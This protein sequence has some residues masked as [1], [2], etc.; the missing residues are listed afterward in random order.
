MTKTIEQYAAESLN[1]Q[2]VRELAD[3]IKSPKYAPRERHIDDEFGVKY[4]TPPEPGI[5]HIHLH[6]GA[7]CTLTR[8]TAEMLVV[9]NVQHGF[10]PGMPKNGR[11]KIWRE[12]TRN[13][14]MEAHPNRI[15]K[16]ILTRH[17]CKVLGHFIS[18]LEHEYHGR[19]A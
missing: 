17:G 15:G 11:D 7:C 12:I 4:K 18:M 6:G 5:V 10:E 19:K 1:I 2:K 16:A 9:M 14:L 13:K 8:K 3:W